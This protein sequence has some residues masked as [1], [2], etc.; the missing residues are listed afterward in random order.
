[1]MKTK[2]TLN[3]AIMKA[4]GW[5]LMSLVATHSWA[6]DSGSTG[7]D[8]S[9]SPIADSGLAFPANGILN[10]TTLNIPAGVT[11][12][13]GPNPAN[14]PA[15]ILVQGDAVIDGVI[16]ISGADGEGVG[17]APAG[18]AG[19][20]PLDDVGGTGQGPGGSIGGSYNFASGGNGG[21]YG[22]LGGTGTNNS[23][24]DRGPVYGSNSMKPL[25]GGSG[26]GGTAIFNP[27]RGYRGGGGG[28]A[29]LIAVS[30]TLTLNGEILAK[31]GDGEP[32]V[33][34]PVSTT[35]GPGA[36]GGSGGGVRLIAT[37]F[38]GSGTINVSGGNPGLGRRFF[39]NTLVSDGG[40]G[41]AGRVRIEADAFNYSGGVTP[42]VAMTAAPSAVFVANLPTIR[43]V[44]IGGSAVPANPVGESD[45]VLPSSIS[46]PVTVEFAAT[47]VP[48]GSVVDL[49][50]APST[51]VSIS[52]SSNGLAGSVADSTATASVNLPQGPSVLYASVSF[53]A[54]GTPLV[55]FSPFTDGEK[56][57]RVELRS[58]L[59]SG[60]SSMRLTTE[61]G[62]IIDVPAALA[63]L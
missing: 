55:M 59:G 37:N 14:G 61:S 3:T 62:R 1:M 22:S 4:L 46:N 27:S 34:E 49:T 26:G 11:V 9:F 51:G 36:G 23:G 44:T 39:N 12:N 7:A 28:G 32:V 21:S 52:V 13:V 15:V 19:G 41:G 57:A 6:F 63:N 29:I 25:L 40:A 17:S 24:T 60:S 30:G 5:V 38:A 48:L 31:G 35:G 56:V 50:V 47:G 10:L 18:F 53:A 8:G 2:A 58:T 42:S 54:A 16:D 43:I 20:L 45:V 33:R